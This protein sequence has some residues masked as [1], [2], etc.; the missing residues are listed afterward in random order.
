MPLDA[1]VDLIIRDTFIKY[2]DREVDSKHVNQDRLDLLLTQAS[3]VFSELAGTRN[4]LEAVDIFH[5]DGKKQQ[6][7]YVR[8]PPIKASPA[9][10]LE[11]WNATAWKVADSITYALEQENATGL[12]RLTSAVFHPVRWRITYT[13]GYLLAAIPIDIQVAVCQLMDR[14]E[15]RASGKE[16]V[17]STSKGD[18]SVNFDLV[19]LASKAIKAV[20]NKYRVVHF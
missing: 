19:N 11:Y 6:R 16:G 12:I 8:Y 17:T 5:F 15:Q 13:G 2:A 3:L 10:V 18:Q 20:A 14:A 9:I 1:T 4:F 7:I